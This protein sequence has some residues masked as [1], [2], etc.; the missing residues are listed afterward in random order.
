MRVENCIISGR[1]NGIFLKSRDGRGGFI[2]NVTGE[3]LVV[4]NSPTFIGINLLNKGIQA[5]DPVA[6]DAEQWTRMSNIPVSATHP[7]AQRR[8]I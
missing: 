7:G 3:N 8:W 6:G 1:Q 2:E 5:S 4:Q